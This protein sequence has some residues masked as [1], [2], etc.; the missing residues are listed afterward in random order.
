MDEATYGGICT[1][2]TVLLP[3]VV[4]GTHTL[5]AVRARYGHSITLLDDGRLLV[6]GGC[7]LDSSSGI[8]SYLNDL[9]QLDTET[10][11]W[12]RPR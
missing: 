7:T 5:L 10:M 8:P 11:V 1:L 12:T 6:F 4:Y 2:C 3:Y 9:R